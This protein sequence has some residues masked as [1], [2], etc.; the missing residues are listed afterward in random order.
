[1][2]T[3]MNPTFELLEQAFPGK[4]W[5]I[6]NLIERR[7]LTTSYASVLQYINSRQ[8]NPPPYGRC[9]MIA[10][11]EVLGDV[12][13]MAAPRVGFWYGEYSAAWHWNLKCV[14][15]TKGN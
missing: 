8:D 3:Q 11:A 4:A 6:S 15:L 12:E 7:T 2:D 1:M 5:E 14:M 13:W 10:I 9:L